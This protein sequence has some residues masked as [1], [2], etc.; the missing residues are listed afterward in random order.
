MFTPS[1]KLSGCFETGGILN[2]CKTEDT[3]LAMLFCNNGTSK[4]S[5]ASFFGSSPLCSFYF[6]PLF[7][8]IY[9]KVIAKPEL[10]SALVLFVARGMEVEL[11]NSLGLSV[12]ALVAR[13][14]TG[15]PVAMSW[16]LLRY[17]YLSNGLQWSSSWFFWETKIT[18]DDGVP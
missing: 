13:E 8:Y 7:L 15:Q 5:R 10:Q 11:L 17:T 12:V 18:V 6:R 2:T 1:T 3:R 4:K 9:H 14:S 16:D